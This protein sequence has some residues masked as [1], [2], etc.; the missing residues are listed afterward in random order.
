MAVVLTLDLQCCSRRVR[1]FFFCP[2]APKQLELHPALVLGED[3]DALR[4]AHSLCLMASAERLGRADRESAKPAR[5]ARP[6]TWFVATA[7]VASL[8]PETPEGR[9]VLQVKIYQT[10][11]MDPS[12]AALELVPCLMQKHG[13]LQQTPL[14]AET[15][16]K[17]SSA[18]LISVTL[19][20]C[21]I[22][23]SREFRLLQD[24]VECLASKEDSNAALVVGS[25]SASPTRPTLGRSATGLLLA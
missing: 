13:P 25:T 16:G 17:S 14:R 21:D 10:T 6:R 4:A 20:L 23:K 1:L 2:R 19:G 12:T 5:P 3:S 15:Y 22:S 11:P 8:E 18:S 24:S 7:R 9:L